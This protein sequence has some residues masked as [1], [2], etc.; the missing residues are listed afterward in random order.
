MYSAH[1]IVSLHRQS[2]NDEKGDGLH[3]PAGAHP[4]GLHQSPL[5]HAVGGSRQPLCRVTRLGVSSPVIQNLTQNL[6]HKG[7]GKAP[8][9][10]NYE[11][12]RR[13]PY[14]YSGFDSPISI[15]NF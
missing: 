5:P 14:A 6:V 12:I 7:F 1:L 9:Y 2:E 4:P 13:G 10:L 15:F 8:F 3:P 11:Y